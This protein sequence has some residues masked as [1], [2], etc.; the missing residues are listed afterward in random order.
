MRTIAT[1][2]LFVQGIA[3]AVALASRADDS[4]PSDPADINPCPV[5]LLRVEGHGARGTAFPIGPNLVATASHCLS[6]SG[7]PC[8]YRLSCEVPTST[9]CAAN[10]RDLDGPTRT[11]AIQPL[12]TAWVIGRDTGDLFAGTLHTSSVEFRDWL[13]PGTPVLGD[14]IVYA[15]D[16]AH[17][18]HLDM[19]PSRHFSGWRPFL[20]SSGSPVVQSGHVV[21]IITQRDIP[22]EEGEGEGRKF[23][24]SMFGGLI[25]KR[26]PAPPGGVYG[27]LKVKEE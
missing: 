13:E 8:P 5:I 4:A 14:A 2:I 9:A 27:L 23:L 26:D 22:S 3:L 10:P 7:C 12:G 11:A 17:A 25:P 6:C 19:P 18:V 16:G 1:L 20:G 15:R 24:R 21:G